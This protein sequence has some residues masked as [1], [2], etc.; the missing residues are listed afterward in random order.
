MEI[1]TKLGPFMKSDDSTSKIMK[2]LLIA[3]LPI[4]LFS[5]YKNGVLL[6]IKGYTNFFGIFYPLIFIILGGLTSMV[7]EEAFLFIFKKQRGNDLIKSVISSYGFIPGLFLSL[8]LPINTPLA[9]VFIGSVVASLIGKMIYGGFGYN[10]FNPALVGAIFVITCYGALIGTR[11]GYL[12]R[13][14]IDT[15]AT[16][17]PRTN[18]QLVDSINYDSIIKPYGSMKDFFIGNIPGSIGET[19]SLL[20]I[21]AFIYLTVTKTI[22][23]RIPLSYVGTFF[24]M[25]IIFDYIVGYGDWYIKYEI[26]SGGLLFGSVFMAT[27]PVTSPVTN[28]GQIL[29]GMSLGFMTF[30]LR[31]LTNYPEGV[32]TSILFM[33]ALVLFF[34]K[35][36]SRI[37]YNKLY[38]IAFAI[39]SIC[40]IGFG[41]YVGKINVKDD[42]K[43]MSSDFAI[44]SKKKNDGNTVY[45]VTQKGFGGNIK[46]RIIFDSRNI[47]SIEVL[48]QYESEDRYALI[49]E[50]D[51]IN[52]LLEN[53]HDLDSVDTISSATITSSALKKMV[54]RTINSYVG[55]TGVTITN[56]HTEII[57]KNYDRDV[58]IYVVR[59]DSFGGKIDV[60]VVMK[61]NT[62]RT[63]IP[64]N[65]NDTCISE[66]K[67]SEYY[68]CPEYLE[69][70]YIN[71]LIINQDSLDSVDTVSGATISS[72][73][74]KDA[75][76]YMKEEGLDG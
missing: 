1:E 68:M 18:M 60:Q 42:E 74:I 30:L 49:E 8:V 11:G 36:G 51:Y 27:D 3:L 53:Q 76:I 58:R 15:I 63:A 57:S 69:Q 70:G 21:I 48:E 50:S 56:P 9:I 72:K 19:S 26:L 14:E 34:D 47:T 41:I 32:M 43:I 67:K 7:T 33:N 17:T 37:E 23:W 73:A 66:S 45:E 4:I 40:I 24:L 25:T 52:K 12:N 38:Y 5:V 59:T 46:A 75:L 64:I 6:Y 62:I 20:I 29:Y 28:K 35:I 22:K 31:Y 71:K 54:S 55:Q 16:A 13:Y 10:I 2:R 61:G 39:L 65:Y 44:L